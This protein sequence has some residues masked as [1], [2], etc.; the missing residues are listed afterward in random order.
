MLDVIGMVVIAV[1]YYPTSITVPI[2]SASIVLYSLV[3]DLV[4]NVNGK[5]TVIVTTTTTSVDVIGMVV[6]AVI[7]Q[8][9]LLCVITAYA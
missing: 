4:H 6:I 8:A 7:P 2:A 3:L 1:M 9:V 5:V